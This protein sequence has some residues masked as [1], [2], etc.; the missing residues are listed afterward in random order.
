VS[1]SVS[2]HHSATHYKH[3]P[4]MH[5]FISYVALIVVSPA[6]HELMHDLTRHTLP[7]TVT[8]VVCAQPGQLVLAPMSYDVC[9]TMPFALQSGKPMLMHALRRET[10]QS[11]LRTACLRGGGRARRRHRH[12]RRTTRRVARRRQHLASATG[13]LTAQTRRCV[14]LLTRTGHAGRRCN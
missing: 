5:P 8:Q 1:A 12:A 6:A 13:D 11:N 4:T 3:L 10:E 7:A 2:N 14:W 9:A